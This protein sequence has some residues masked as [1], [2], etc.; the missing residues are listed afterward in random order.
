[1]TALEVIWPRHRWD[2]LTVADPDLPV[3]PPPL[4]ST[5]ASAPVRGRSRV[6]VVAGERTSLSHHARSKR[7][8]HASLDAAH[9]QG[10]ALAVHALLHGARCGEGHVDALLGV[11]RRTVGRDRAAPVPTAPRSS[12]SRRRASPPVR[13]AG[14]RRRNARQPRRGCRRGR[15]RPP[16]LAGARRRWRWRCP[17]SQAPTQ[18]R[19]TLDQLDALTR[20]Q[21]RITHRSALVHYV[22]AAEKQDGQTL[23]L[24]DALAELL[25]DI[26]DA[27]HTIATILQQVG[28]GRTPPTASAR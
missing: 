4:P 10:R 24:G 26:T 7:R 19:L 17:P 6:P 14:A 22:L 5:W 2:Y 28:N 16:R 23:T 8:S 11:S 27:A 25:E 21:Q 12:R 9:Q 15:V 18:A 3:N 20:Q 1:M 13:I